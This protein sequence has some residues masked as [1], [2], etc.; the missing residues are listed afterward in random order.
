MVS[1]TSCFDAKAYPWRSFLYSV[2][3]FALFLTPLFYGYC[4]YSDIQD[5]FEI[6]SGSERDPFPHSWADLMF[7][8]VTA[9][10]FCLFC[11]IVI[12]SA[13]RLLAWLL[14]GRDGPAVPQQGS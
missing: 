14:S 10:P 11:A 3:V 5:A 4:L 9:F 6:G 7:G 1:Q 8:L 12:M 2:L 13:Y